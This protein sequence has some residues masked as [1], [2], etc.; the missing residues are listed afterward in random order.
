[1]TESEWKQVEKA[2]ENVYS[3]GAELKFDGFDVCLRLRQC[4][5]FKNAI[6]VYVNGEFQGKWLTE[7]CE[8]RR[9]F[10]PRKRKSVVSEKDF[11]LY[12]IRSKKAKQEFRERYAYDVYLNAWTS[13]QKMRKHFEANNQIIELTEA[14]I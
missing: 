7:D 5:Q 8:E 9:R 1:M 11:K 2:L 6:F 12:G 4:S 13:F 10:F 14:F 3:F